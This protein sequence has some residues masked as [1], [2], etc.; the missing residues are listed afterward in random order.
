MPWKGNPV[1]NV[2]HLTG[3]LHQVKMASCAPTSISLSLTLMK[4][5]LAKPLINS[6]LHLQLRVSSSQK[7]PVHFDIQARMSLSTSFTM[8]LL[9]LVGL[10]RLRQWPQASREA[11]AA[12]E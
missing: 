8:K 6:F 2:S 12:V 7:R 9:G 3:M 5:L 11:C 10:L 4:G 1:S